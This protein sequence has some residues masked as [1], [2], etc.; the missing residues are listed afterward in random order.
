[1]EVQEFF[2]LQFQKFR[3]RVPKGLWYAAYDMWGRVEGDEAVV[4]VTDFLQTKVGD[5]AYVLPENEPEFEQDDTF[6]TLESFK[7]TIDLTIPISGAVVTFNPALEQNPELVNEDPYG[8]GW[9]VRLRLSAW[10]E[11]REML[12]TPEQYL[13]LMEEK[14]AIELS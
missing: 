9:I 6:C 12:L 11:D 14:V 13:K 8:A 10:D 2:E 4:G 5:L 3:L 7:A 1:M